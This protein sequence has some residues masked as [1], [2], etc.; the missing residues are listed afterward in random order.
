[1]AAAAAC[2]VIAGLFAKTGFGYAFDFLLAIVFAA[3]AIPLVALLVALLVIIARKLPPMATGWIVGSCT[4][5]MLLW[6]PPELGIPMAVVVGLAEGILGAAIATFVSGGLR[7]AALSKKIVVGVLCLLALSAN[8]YIGW[9][10]V[11]EGSMEKILKWR[12]PADLMPAKLSLPN[13]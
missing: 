3:I 6:F 13:P 4:I 1:M 7:E 8:G 2:V 12:P 11:H 10:L 9:L 5:V